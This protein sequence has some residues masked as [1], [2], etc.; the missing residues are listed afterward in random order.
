M[1]VEI[2][3]NIGDVLSQYILKNDGAIYLENTG[4]TKTD[5]N[6]SSSDDKETFLEGAEEI[7]E[8][9]RY[10]RSAELRKKALE[11]YPNLR[12]YVC[13]FNFKDFY[14]DYGAGYIEVHHLKLIADSERENTVDDVRIVCS[15]CH[16]VL[17]RKAKMPMDIDELRKFIEKKRARSN[18]RQLPIPK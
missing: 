8:E 18:T 11:K 9:K 1:S 16:S 12:C 6:K 7:Y 15:N 17:H 3:E 2:I 13:N 14:E 4:K 5:K 10:K